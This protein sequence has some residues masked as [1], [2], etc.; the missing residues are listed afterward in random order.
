MP[1]AVEHNTAKTTEKVGVTT[2]TIKALDGVF[3]ELVGEHREVATLI[4]RL[5]GTDDQ[6][7]RRDTWLEVSSALTAHERGE[8][9]EVY[10]AFEGYPPRFST[11]STNTPT[12]P[13]DWKR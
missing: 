5:N 6:K 10:K 7:K 9:Q 12:K 1:N 4:K 2:A 13:I 3:A 11:S 8:L